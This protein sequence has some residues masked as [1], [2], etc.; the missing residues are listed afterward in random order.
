MTLAII[1]YHNHQN[2]LDD[3]RLVPTNCVPSCVFPS[4]E[5]RY[6][7]PVHEH[8]L[9]GPEA[10]CLLRHPDCWATVCDSRRWWK[11]LG[12]RCVY[13]WY[14]NDYQCMLNLLSSAAIFFEIIVWLF[15]YWFRLWSLRPVEF[16]LPRSML[17]I[18]PCIPMD[19]HFS[20]GSPGLI[21]KGSKLSKLCRFIPCIGGHCGEVEV[22]L[23]IFQEQLTEKDGKRAS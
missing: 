7:I 20:L 6:A 3:F 17:T 18:N 19:V 8:C 14:S 1:T 4:F 21:V 9:G 10:P 16:N 5:R 13:Q 22:S 11:T 23:L 12:N 15:S 2:H